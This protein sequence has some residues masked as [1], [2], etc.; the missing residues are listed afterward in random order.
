M[1]NSTESYE[2]REIRNEEYL[3]TPRI[4]IKNSRTQTKTRSVITRR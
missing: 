4:V 2:D 3:E 1:A